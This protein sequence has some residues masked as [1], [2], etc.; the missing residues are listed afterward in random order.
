M[1]REGLDAP[2][3][4]AAVLARRL[5]RTR[6]EAEGHAPGGVAA[7]ALTRLASHLEEEL[8]GL[9]APAPRWEGTVASPGAWRP[10]A[11]RRPPL[12]PDPD[13]GP[14]RATVEGIRFDMARNVWVTDRIPS[15]RSWWLSLR[16]AAFLD[17]ELP[18]VLVARDELAARLRELAP[19]EEG[20][21]DL[22]DDLVAA[23]SHESGEPADLLGLAVD[24]QLAATDAGDR[25]VGATWQLSPR[26]VGTLL[27][28]LDDED[29]REALRDAAVRARAEL[30]VEEDGA[31]QELAEV[32]E[33]YPGD[34]AWH[35][36]SHWAWIN[37]ATLG[38]SAA[39]AQAPGGI[40]DRSRR[41]LTPALARERFAGGPTK[42]R[43]VLNDRYRLHVLDDD[44]YRAIFRDH[45]FP[46]NHEFLSGAR[47]V[48][49]AG[50]LT[51]QG[52][53]VVA[54][55]DD[56][57]MVPGKLPEGLPPIRAVLE[58][59]GYTL[60]A[61]RVDASARVLDWEG[62][63]VAADALEAPGLPTDLSDE[64]EAR[65]TWLATRDF[66]DLPGAAVA[67]LRAVAADGAGEGADRARAAAPSAAGVLRGFRVINY[68]ARDVAS[69]K[70]PRGADLVDEDLAAYLV[71]RVLPR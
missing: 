11:P 14:A 12:D 26:L 68:G 58:A 55:E 5:R 51:F 25:P 23:A 50:Y 63:E 66:A 3:A 2:E 27:G 1:D 4:R 48:V 56:G 57:L 17:W 9:D 7:A 59:R 62:F 53:E 20:V 16:M 70:L 52:G 13:H 46:P 65:A 42:V 45:G 41:R 39:Q 38:V 28:V 64:E 18:G 34:P 47:P 33:R 32:L 24:V 6:R 30:T 69:G 37:L 8:V 21:Q 40:L 35:R 15:E 36:R 43:F 60:D 67:L 44:E 61:A 29:Q 10:V 31:R 49:A 19:G 22:V 71:R 54:I